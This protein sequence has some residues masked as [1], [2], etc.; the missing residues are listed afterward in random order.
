MP[1]GYPSASAMRTLLRA[2]STLGPLRRTPCFS[3]SMWATMEGR[4]G[5]P[6]AYIY[7]QHN[8]RSAP[9][10]SFSNPEPLLHR[11]SHS[12]SPLYYKP[13]R[14]MV[15]ARQLAVDPDAPTVPVLPPIADAAVREQVFTHPSWN[16]NPAAAF[17][18]QPGAARDYTHLAV[19]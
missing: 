2:S 10:S 11:E 19:G 16:G 17:E 1:N 6:A 5:R 13:S 14:T 8:A 7:S 9:F 12:S 15:I 4:L 3:V 18:Q